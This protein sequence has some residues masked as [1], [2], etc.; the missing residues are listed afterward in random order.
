M[1]RSREHFFSNGGLQRVRDLVD[2]VC[3]H[4]PEERECDLMIADEIGLRE[5]DRWVLVHRKTVDRWVV[6]AGLDSLVSESLADTF[7][8]LGTA[9]AQDNGKDVVGRHTR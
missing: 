3:R 7:P 9:V 1:Q 4:S 5:T 6:N 8:A 2:L